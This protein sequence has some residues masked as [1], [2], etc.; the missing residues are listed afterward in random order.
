MAKLIPLGVATLAALLGAAVPSV[1]G[2][3][4]D[5]VTL[6]PHRAFYDLKL[7][8]SNGNR[9]VNAV[10]GRILY[11]FS[12]SACEGYELKFRQISELD[13]L[14]TTDSLSDLNSTTW[15]DGEAK[16]FRFNSENKVNQQPGD[17]VAGRADHGDHSLA[18]R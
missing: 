14:E 12:G 6:A 9:G 11:D 16:R 7:S 5:G 2:A 1:E 18:V 3:P 8:R 10:Q 13:S 17:L 4:A 15:E